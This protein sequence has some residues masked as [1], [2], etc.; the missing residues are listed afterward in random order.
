M[1]S[2]QRTIIS[3]Y[4]STFWVKA[5]MIKLNHYIHSGHC[6][7]DLVEKKNDRTIAQA[8]AI[9]WKS[10]YEK[11]NKKFINS[12]KEKIINKIDYFKNKKNNNKLIFENGIFSDKDYLSPSYINISNPK[13]FEIDN[14]YYSTLIIIN[15]FREQQD[16]ILKSIIDTNIDL[17]I[18]IFYEK[19]DT[20]KTIRDLTYRNRVIWRVKKGINR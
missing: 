18:S 11:I 8:R 14:N 17:N 6:Y 5:D 12:I 3:R 16:L 4:G 9:I 1:Q 10:D 2:I 20:Y 15:Y 19:Q 7:P 13:Y